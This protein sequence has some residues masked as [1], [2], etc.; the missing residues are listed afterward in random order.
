M[1]SPCRNICV[2]DPESGFCIGCGRTR[3]EIARWSR[4]PMTKKRD[5]V[6]ALPDRLSAITT[7]RP[8]KGRKGRIKGG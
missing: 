1:S 6:M 7:Q 8:R 4:L 5:I 3:E 2:L